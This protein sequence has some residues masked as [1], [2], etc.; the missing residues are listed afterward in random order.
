[1]ARGSPELITLF[2][3][4]I[5]DEYINEYTASFGGRSVESLEVDFSKKSS[6]RTTICRDTISNRTQSIK[7]V[8]AK[9]PRSLRGKLFRMGFVP[10]PKIPT[11]TKPAY[12]KFHLSSHKRNISIE[13][14]REVILPNIPPINLIYKNLFAI[15]VDSPVVEDY[16][17][18]RGL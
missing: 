13:T 3:L 15:M 16:L 17:D 1:M 18:I 7:P 10:Y 14:Y 6:V 9:N 5:E 8:M 12:L 11:T 2:N 4:L